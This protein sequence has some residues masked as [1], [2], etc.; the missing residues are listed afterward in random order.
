MKLVYV[1]GRYRGASP[2]QTAA[3]CRLADSM[4]AC[5]FLACGGAVYP[6][7][8]HNNTPQ[9]WEPLAQQDFWLDATLELMRRCDAVYVPTASCDVNRG[10]P[11]ASAR[12]SRLWRRATISQPG[13]A[14]QAD[15][16]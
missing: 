2:E 8:P 3:H 12:P 4:A 9:H 13:N 11:I 6:V 14:T 16:R 5:L 7:V 1:A 10:M 15:G